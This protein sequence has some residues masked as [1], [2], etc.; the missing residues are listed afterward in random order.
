MTLVITT[1]LS[2]QLPEVGMVVVTGSTDWP[3][4]HPLPPF[5]NPTVPGLFCSPG[6]CICPGSARQMPTCPRKGPVIPGK[7]QPHVGG[8]IFLQA[9]WWR[10]SGWSSSGQ[11]L[12]SEVLSDEQQPWGFHENSPACG[13][14]FLLALFWL[15]DSLV[16]S[17][18]VAG[19]PLR[20]LTPCSN[21][22]LLKLV[23][24]DSVVCN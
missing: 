14:L 10:S 4:Q 22:L 12:A 6:F 15:C 23:R 17:P 1:L 5:L 9:W 7:W 24:V 20:Y 21:P 13:W 16:S 19:K 2:H 18:S 8:S 3:T 11:P